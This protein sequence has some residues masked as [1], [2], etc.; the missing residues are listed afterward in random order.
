[1]YPLV[2]CSAWLNTRGDNKG[3]IFCKI[4]VSDSAVRIVYDEPWSINCLIEFMRGRPRSSGFR[5]WLCKKLTGYSF[6][7]G[8]LQ[9]LRFLGVMDSAAMKWFWMTGQTAYL[10]F[11]E[12]FNDQA[13]QTVPEDN[14][15]EELHA[16]SKAQRTLAEALESEELNDIEDWLDEGAEGSLRIAS[17]FATSYTLSQS[18][19]ISFL[20]IPTNRMR[21]G[22]VIG[23]KNFT[24]RLLSFYKSFSSFP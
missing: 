4:M 2:A 16:H 3:F 14:S 23:I 22:K 24:H 9:N 7:R 15:S 8:G 10:T 20:P 21:I 6:K 5:K 11:T 1:M 17:N 19:L 13:G 12:T 18:G